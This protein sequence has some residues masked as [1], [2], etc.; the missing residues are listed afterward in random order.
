MKNIAL[1]AILVGGLAA[2]LCSA[3][4]TI[5]ASVEVLV[6]TFNPSRREAHVSRD[7]EQ[8]AS[9]QLFLGLSTL[10]TRLSRGLLSK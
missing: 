8:P 2:P 6:S 10:R 5:A 9:W 1:S 4:P 3:Q 7:S